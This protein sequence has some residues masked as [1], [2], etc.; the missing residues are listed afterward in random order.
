MC[1]DS[2]ADVHKFCSKLTYDDYL[3]LI[4][5]WQVYVNL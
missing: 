4:I 3:N 2:K 1:Y 5:D